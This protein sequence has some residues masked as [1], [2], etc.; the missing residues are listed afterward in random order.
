MISSRRLRPIASRP[1]L[2][3]L[4]LPEA[5]KKSRMRSAGLRSVSETVASVSSPSVL[6][7]SLDSHSEY[8][9]SE[10]FNSSDAEEKRV[11]QETEFG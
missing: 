4:Y 11:V 6:F 7:D 9:T 3:S 2:S 8:G 1:F 10:T 5:T